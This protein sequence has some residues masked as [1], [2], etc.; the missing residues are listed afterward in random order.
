LRS[1]YNKNQELTDMVY[2]LQKQLESVTTGRVTE[3]LQARKADLSNVLGADDYKSVVEQFDTRAGKPGAFETMVMR[4]AAAEWDASQGKRDLSPK[5]AV[6]EVLKLI[7][8]QPSQPKAADS[9]PPKVITQ[10]KP[11]VLPEVGGGTASPTALKRPAST[12][13]LRE[14]YKKMAAGG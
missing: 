8:H 11:A 2:D 6:E 3:T 12:A 5:E 14:I 9:Q 13:E 7:G 10:K 4:H 1:F